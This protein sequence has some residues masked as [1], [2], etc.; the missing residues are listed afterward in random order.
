MRKVV[1]GFIV[2]LANAA[3][4]REY[5]FAIVPKLLDNPVFN[6]A[7]I[8]AE[9]QAKKLGNVKII[10]R[11]PQEADAAKQVE[12]I[13]SLIALKVDGISVSCNEPEALRAVIDKAVAAG[14][15]TITFDSDSPKS[16]RLTY[17]G[18]NDFECGRVMGRELAK[19]MKNKGE[20]VML[21]GM[22]GAFNLEE[23]MKGVENTLK[24]RSRMK[25][26]QTVACDDDIAKSVSLIESTMRARPALGGWAFVGGWP[27]FASGAL[28]SVDSKKTKVV[29]WDALPPEWP[30]LESGKVSMLL[31]QRVYHWGSESVKLLMKASAGKR[32]PRYSYAHLDLV[33]PRNLPKY[34][35][36]WKSWDDPNQPMQD[37]PILGP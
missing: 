7:K 24:Q 6:Y 18:I 21:T 33:T 15:P 17:Y 8:G 27:L 31:A 32:L 13:E 35:E 37:F 2:L 9:K 30:Y 11:A 34:K 28:E 5:T 23:R 4:A 19:A 3:W 22:R 12:I 26:V 25:I 16:R 29:S 36:M 1:C 20:V 10:W 14:I